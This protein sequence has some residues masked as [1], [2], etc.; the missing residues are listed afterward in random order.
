MLSLLDPNS[1]R[2]SQEN[3]VPAYKQVDT[4]N[5]LKRVQAQYR[6]GGDMYPEEE[7]TLQQQ[8]NTDMKAYLNYIKALENKKSKFSIYKPILNKS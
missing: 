4:S 8:N 3:G 2:M 7:N 1:V 5:V 6:L